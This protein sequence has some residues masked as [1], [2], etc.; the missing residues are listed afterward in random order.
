[1]KEGAGFEGAGE[2]VILT[3]VTVVVHFVVVDV[4]EVRV[5]LDGSKI[6]GTSNRQWELQQW[7]SAT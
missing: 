7:R 4:Q 2:M 5:V 1:M 6:E 3:V